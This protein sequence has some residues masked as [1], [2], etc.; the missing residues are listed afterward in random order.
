LEE[1]ELDEY[2]YLNRLV[3]GLKARALRDLK[4]AS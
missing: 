3:S 1:A 4:V 2:E